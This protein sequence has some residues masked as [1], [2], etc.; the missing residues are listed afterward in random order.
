MLVDSA[1][2]RE[3]ARMTPGGHAREGA[4]LPVLFRRARQLRGGASGTRAVSMDCVGSCR[5]GSVIIMHT[6]PHTAL[7]KPNLDGAC[8]RS[9]R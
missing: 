2:G 3:E 8:D 6:A 4:K 9:P 5:A 1:C 7:K